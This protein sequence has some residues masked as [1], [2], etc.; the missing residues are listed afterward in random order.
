MK[1]AICEGGKERFI[2]YPSSRPIGA[3]TARYAANAIRYIEAGIKYGEMQST[4]P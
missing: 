1:R 3:L 2:L 4:L